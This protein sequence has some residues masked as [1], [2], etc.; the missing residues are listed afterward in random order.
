MNQVWTEVRSNAP[1]KFRL[2]RS[3][4]LLIKK[5]AQLAKF[6]ETYRVSEKVFPFSV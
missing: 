2:S 5:I 4:G 1:S 6:V 3:N